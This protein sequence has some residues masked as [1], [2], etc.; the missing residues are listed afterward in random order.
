VRTI[1]KRNEPPAFVEWRVPRLAAHAAP[2]MV[3]NYEELRRHPAVIAAVADSLL[4]EQGSICAYTGVR[5][6]AGSSHIEHLKPQKYCAYGEDADYKNLVACWP[7]PNCAFE[8]EYGA[9]KKGSWPSPDETALFVSP[10]SPRC[11]ERFVFNRHGEINPADAA[12]AAAKE[13]ITRLG[14]D[15]RTLTEYRRQAIRGALAPRSKPIRLTDARRLLH[16]LDD[17]AAR[18]DSGEAVTLSP[19]CFAVRQL[20]AKEI[21]KLEAIVKKP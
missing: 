5:I 6:A 15:H 8:P 13:T 19:F 10:L 18:L 2:G 9:R 21:R 12:D 20:V 3:C 1:K 7:E 11:D 4:A 16:R 17:D 14:L